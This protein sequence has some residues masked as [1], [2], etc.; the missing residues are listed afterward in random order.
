MNRHAVPAQNF[1]HLFAAFPVLFDNF[2]G[3]SHLVET[4]CQTSRNSPR[5]DNHDSFK[6]AGVL[7]NKICAEFFNR[8]RKSDKICAVM[9]LKRI[10]AVRDNHSVISVNQARQNSRRQFQIFE[11]NICQSAVFSDFCLEQSNFSV[12][13]IVN[14]QRGGSHQNSVNFIRGDNFGIYQQINIE[15]FFHVL[16]RLADKLHVA[17]SG[18]CVLDAVIFRQNASNHVHFVRRG[19]R[20]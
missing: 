11:R 3:N 7:L 12:R 10:V 13:K 20:N 16:A 17:D 15:I 2:N 9:S 5:A 14:V 18:Y 1:R 19:N 8:L 4:N 6:R